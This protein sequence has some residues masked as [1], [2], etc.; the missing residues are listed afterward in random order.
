VGGVCENLVEIHA[1]RSGMFTKAD[2]KKGQGNPLKRGRVWKDKGGSAP[3][4]RRL[5]KNW[6][7]MPLAKGRIK[8]AENAD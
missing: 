3:R 7:H 6:H 4:R 8:S 2:P 1:K 5:S